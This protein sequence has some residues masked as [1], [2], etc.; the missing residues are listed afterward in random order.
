MSSTRVMSLSAANSPL[1]S[2]EYPGPVLKIL[3]GCTEFPIRPIERERFLI[4]AGSQCSIQLGADGIPIVHTLIVRTMLGYEVEALAAYPE[5]TLN[6]RPIRTAVLADGDQ[7]ALGD[8]E[9][10][11]RLPV[12]AQVQVE[13]DNAIL[14]VEAI[15]EQ[16]EQ[17]EANEFR[18]MSIDE[19]VSGL[20]QFV[21][22]FEVRNQQ[23]EQG[24]AAMMQSAVQGSGDD[25]AELASELSEWSQ[26]MEQRLRTISARDHEK[27]TRD[28]NSA[29]GPPRLRVSA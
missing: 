18:E 10:E 25:A 21:Q 28:Q 11:F 9:M 27:V 4:G 23:R 26:Q 17:E 5:L 14:D 13:P 24:M 6:G 1:D 8:F 16:V 7:I 20:E 15:M 12:A 19:L 29:G 2:H 22:D 3:R